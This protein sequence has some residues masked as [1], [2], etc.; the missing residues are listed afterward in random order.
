VSLQRDYILRLVEAFAKAIAG[1]AALRRKGA[2]QEARVELD[3][4]GGKLLGIELGL[5]AAIGPRAVAAQLGHPE[6][7]A[8][9]ADLLAERAEIERAAGRA[10]EAERWAGWAA[11]IRAPTA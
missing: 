1:V 5:V 6:K 9:L 4:A 11:E 2:Y 10:A 3:Q 8:R 7:V